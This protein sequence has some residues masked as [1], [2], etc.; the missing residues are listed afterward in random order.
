MSGSRKLTP[1]EA[2]AKIAKDKAREEVRTGRQHTLQALFSQAVGLTQQVPLIGTQD[3]SPS[4]VVTNGSG[5]VTVVVSG[6]IGAV[7]SGALE[8]AHVQAAEAAKKAEEEAKAC[9]ATA[10]AVIECEMERKAL[11]FRDQQAKKSK[12]GSKKRKKP[13]SEAGQPPE[14]VAKGRKQRYTDDQKRQCLKV[15]ADFGGRR[16][17]AVAAIHSRFRGFETV[18]RKTLKRWAENDSKTGKPTLKNPGRPVVASSAF[19]QQVLDE[20]VF[21]RIVESASGELTTE[22]VANVCYSHAMIQSA[23]RDVLGRDEWLS[24]TKLQGLKFSHDW[25]RLFAARASLKRL[26]VTT[27][28]SPGTPTPKE[29]NAVMSRIQSDSHG[30]CDDLR[31]NMDETGMNPT[32]AAYQFVGVDQSRAATRDF[33]AKDRVTALIAGTASGEFLPCTFIIKCSSTKAPPGGVAG[34]DQTNLKVLKD[35]LHTTT[36][37]ASKGWEYNVRVW[38]R[39]VWV[40]KGRTKTEKRI[41]F[42]RG[43][44]RNKHTG[45]VILA[46]SKA[47]ADSAAVEMWIHYVLVPYVKNKR[48]ELGLRPDSPALLV[49]DNAPAHKIVGDF[50]KNAILARFLPANCTSE[51]QVDECM[52]VTRFSSCE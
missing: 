29:I 36:F 31:I 26:K 34:C 49:W 5:N 43:F 46:Q 1:A 13:A 9:E 28:V 23:A 27:K 48:T 24:D 22:T 8:E 30:V 41:Q 37:S 2:A 17:P 3:G 14:K 39:L 45:E 11:E 38:H 4:I 7:A 21:Q 50:D 12:E 51:L 20:L 19:E 32:G 25:C 16:K 40:G 6:A 47:W 44:L 52:L 42:K 33:G 18:D 15:L 35:L 10:M